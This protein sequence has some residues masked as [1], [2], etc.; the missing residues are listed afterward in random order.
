LKFDDDGRLTP[1]LD[2]K[3]F[4]SL[5]E[6]IA[7]QLLLP[8]RTTG[9]PPLGTR[10]SSDEVWSAVLTANP[11]LTG[12]LARAAKQEQSRP[13]STPAERP[14]EDVHPT[15]TSENPLEA[16]RSSGAPRRTLTAKVDSF[17]ESLA[18]PI[19]DERLRMLT[20]E[21]S[22]INHGKFPTA[23]TFLVRALV[24]QT[25]R[26]CIRT[27]NLWSA[28]QQELDGKAGGKQR[29]ADPKLAELIKFCI[30]HE[31]EMFTERNIKK[32]LEQWQARDNIFCNIVVHAEWLK[33]NRSSLEQIASYVRPF[34]QKVFDGQAL[35]P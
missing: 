5:I 22:Q 12:K 27:K 20:T 32:V 19:P 31:R 26:H 7:R 10:A 28:L 21:I 35:T 29:D 4:D 25:L 6:G 13:A 30:R 15:S 24:E 14:S 17:F 8:V 3:L 34:I 33:A 23:A 1:A 16:P 2:A 11:T 9:K 18:C